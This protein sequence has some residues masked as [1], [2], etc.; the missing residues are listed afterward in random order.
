MLFGDAEPLGQIPCEPDDNPEN[1]WGQ[2]QVDAAPAQMMLYEGMR[3]RITKNADKEHGFVNG[4]GA[5]LQRMRRSGAQV[6]TD[7]GEILLIHP[8]TRDIGLSDGCTRR[9]T[10]FPLRPGYSTTLHEIQ[11]ATLPHITIWMDVPFVR[12]A[13][14]V[15]LS[16][17]RY[18]RDWRFIGEIDRRHCL[19]ANLT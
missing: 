10:A 18:D 13:L 16:R 1:F 17:V 6:R 19:P 12:A 2:T 11:G 14:Y 15:A 7:E 4:M 5:V 8:I 9:V 3:V